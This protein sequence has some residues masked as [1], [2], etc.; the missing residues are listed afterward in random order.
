MDLT[1]IS[2]AISEG[3]VVIGHPGYTELFREVCSHLAGA[4]LLLFSL[5]NRKV[6]CRRRELDEELN[7]IK[8]KCL[9]K[10]MSLLGN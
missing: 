4:V 2:V 5:V 10:Y 1:L 8:S 6:P 7:P 3:Y 9:N